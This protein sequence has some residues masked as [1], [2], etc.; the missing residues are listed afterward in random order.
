MA[1]CA[2]LTLSSYDGC[3]PAGST[4]LFIPLPSSSG[5]CPP[6]C[7]PPS[8]AALSHLYLVFP[9]SFRL[10]SVWAVSVFLSSC[11]IAW[12][13]WKRVCR[14]SAAF[15]MS[16]AFCELLPSLSLLVPVA[17]S[18]SAVLAGPS[19]RLCGFGAHPVSVCGVT[20]LLPL[21]VV[22]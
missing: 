14:C 1:H 13:F 18:L 12:T 19:S 20:L 8:P 16:R 17:F 21:S 4:S 9:H 7:S 15:A 3:V 10:A 5:V 11:F 22:L 6:P 2:G